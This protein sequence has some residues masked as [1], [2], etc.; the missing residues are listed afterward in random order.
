MTNERKTRQPPW[1]PRIETLPEFHTG[2]PPRD[3]AG[4]VEDPPVPLDEVDEDLDGTEPTVVA[5][6]TP[7]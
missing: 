4:E 1:Q 2:V 7:R 5:A 3:L 6:G